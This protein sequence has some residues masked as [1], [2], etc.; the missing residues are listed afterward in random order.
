MKHA[1]IGLA[2]AAL[3]S[4]CATVVPALAP[5]DPRDVADAARHVTCT[6]DD[7]C[8]IK[9]DRASAWVKAN[10]VLPLQID[11]ATM[12]MTQAPMPYQEDLGFLIAKVGPEIQ[13]TVFCNAPL[14]CKPS[15]L[16]AKA[17]FVRAVLDQ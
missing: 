12:L 11:G 6:T 8:R 10:S 1:L 15:N 9:W 7:D 14:G 16:Q 17:R 5:D 13:L 3:L 4:G 2:T